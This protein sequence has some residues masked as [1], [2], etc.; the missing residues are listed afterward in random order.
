MD[1]NIKLMCCWHVMK[2]IVIRILFLFDWKSAEE[3]KNLLDTKYIMLR[4]V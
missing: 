1:N 4:I 2:S 3:N